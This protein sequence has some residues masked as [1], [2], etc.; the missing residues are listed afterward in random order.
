M[1]KQRS[2]AVYPTA[3]DARDHSWRAS[4]GRA[5]LAVGPRVRRNQERDAFHDQQRRV[6]LRERP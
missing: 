1:G 2:T 3:S 5:W 6:L 4:W